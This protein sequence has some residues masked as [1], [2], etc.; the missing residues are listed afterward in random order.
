M[1]VKV[2]NRNLEWEEYREGDA[3]LVDPQ[4]VLTVVGPAA[5]PQDERDL[6]AGWAA[7]MWVRAER[8]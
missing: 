6:V 8:E 2:Q 4:G 1:A 5:G 3:W 7:G